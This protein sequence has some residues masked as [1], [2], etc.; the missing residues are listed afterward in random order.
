[1]RGRLDGIE[2]GAGRVS[3]FIDPLPPMTKGDR[4]ITIAI[5]VWATIQRERAREASIAGDESWAEIQKS[6]ELIEQRARELKLFY[7][8]LPG[9][10]ITDLIEDE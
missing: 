6:A 4:E 2:I 3:E 10:A 8:S 9:D 1:M 5:S 7:V